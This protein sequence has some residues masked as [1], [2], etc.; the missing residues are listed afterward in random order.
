MLQ[1]ESEIAQ[2]ENQQ[3]AIKILLNSLYGALG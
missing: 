1:L 2:L 3:M